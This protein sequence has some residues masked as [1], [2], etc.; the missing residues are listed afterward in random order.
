MCGGFFVSWR[1]R[2]TKPAC[3]VSR[4]PSL[5]D[6]GHLAI[7]FHPIFCDFMGLPSCWPLGNQ[8]YE[9]VAIVSGHKLGQ[10]QAGLAVTKVV[11]TAAACKITYA[12]RS[13]VYSEGD[14]KVFSSE[15]ISL[16]DPGF[17]PWTSPLL[18]LVA[19]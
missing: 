15:T 17:L 18:V 8:C 10:P 9:K 16:F 4:E 7:P 5:G 6:Y 3:P 2:H 12:S 1:T 13:W 14:A 11:T 19:P